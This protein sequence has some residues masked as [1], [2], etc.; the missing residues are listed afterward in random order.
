M[1]SM[2]TVTYNASAFLVEELQRAGVV[3]RFEHDGGDIILFQLWSGQR[4]SIHLIESSIQMY[5]IRQTLADN[6][7]NDI[8]TLFILWGDRMLPGDGQLYEADDWLAAFYSLYDNQ[9]YAYDIYG[10]EI[11]IFPVHFDGYTNERRVRYG[12]TVNMAHLACDTINTTAPNFTGFWRVAGFT[13]AKRHTQQE[14]PPEAEATLETYYDVLGIDEDATY[15]LVRKAYRL[16]ARRYHPDLNK[17][18]NATAK[19]QQ[20]NEAYDAIIEALESAAGE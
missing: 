9:V 12:T 4:V 11:F 10:S 18:P 13:T 16:L 8:H 20:I 1:A 19:M 17:S 6:S 15:E 2:R 5:E 14:A 7:A 3:A